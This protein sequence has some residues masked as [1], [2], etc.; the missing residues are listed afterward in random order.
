MINISDNWGVRTEFDYFDIDNADL[1]T[2]A[3]GLEYRF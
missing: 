3:M 2:L 1:W